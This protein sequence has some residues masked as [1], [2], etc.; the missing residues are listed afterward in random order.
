M[1]QR[2]LRMGRT[3]LAVGLLAMGMEFSRPVFGCSRVLWSS[4]GDHYLVTGRTTDV[5]FSDQPKIVVFPR[6]QAHTGGNFAN[7]A[8]WTTRYGTLAVAEFGNPN[9]VGE[10]MNT[11]GLAAHMLYLDDTK[12]E[13]RD[14]RPGVSVLLWC[15]YVLD[16]ARTV[17][18]ALDLHRT[19]Q[20]VPADN[21][22]GIEVMSHLMIEDA[23]GDSAIIEFTDGKMVVYHDRAYKVGTNEPTYDQQLANLNQ[24]K[25]FNPNGLPLPGDVDPSSRFVRA[26]AYLSTLPDPASAREAVLTMFSLLRSVSSPLGSM[27]YSDNDATDAWPT[28]WCNVCDLKNRVFYMTMTSQNNLIWIDLKRV[29]FSESLYIKSLD[30]DNAALV[31]D[32]TDKL[33][34]DI[35]P[36]GSLGMFGLSILVA[37][38][39]GLSRD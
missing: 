30:P 13:P 21:I 16:N 36:C 10:G 38:A 33:Q 12:Y 26:S 35:P 3:L 27:D 29:D 7:A 8:T 28:Y 24:Y 31:G 18:E 1:T 5:P 9:V 25:P 14:H 19:F 32:V 6:G 20:V 22:E 4:K 37:L 23:T 2:N 15:Q 17:Q 39:H 11:H 34:S